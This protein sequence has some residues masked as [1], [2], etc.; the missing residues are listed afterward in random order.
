MTAIANQAGLG[1]ALE[2]FKQEFGEPAPG[3]RLL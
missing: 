1:R 3:A 2:I